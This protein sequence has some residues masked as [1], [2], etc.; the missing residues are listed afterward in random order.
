MARIVI[1]DDDPT[2]VALVKEVLD[3]HEILDA[4]NGTDGLALV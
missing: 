2:I 4:G 1:V 3:G